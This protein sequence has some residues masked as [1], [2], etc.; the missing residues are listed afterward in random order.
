MP[1]SKWHTRWLQLRDYQLTYYQD[2]NGKELGFFRLSNVTGLLVAGVG[3]DSP[4]PEQAPFAFAI[5]VQVCL[6][7]WGLLHSRCAW[8]AKR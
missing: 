2:Q 6:L 4:K 1:G 5:D 3:L 7:G 8:S